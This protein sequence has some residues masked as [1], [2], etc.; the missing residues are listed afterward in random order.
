MDKRSRLDRLVAA[1]KGQDL[2]WVL[3]TLPENIFYYS[4]FRT[5][6][7]TR[8]I[9]VLVPVRESREP[10]LI[11]SYIDNKLVRE[12]IWSPHWFQEAVVWGPSDDFKHKTHW[13]ALAAYLKPG[14]KIGVDAVQL[15]FYD[16]L[17]KLFPGLKVINLQAAILDLRMVKGPDE[18]DKIKKAFKLAEEVMARVPE[19]LSP[20]ATESDVAAEMNYAA[21]KA[22]AD[23]LFYPTLVSCGPK[24]SAYHSPPLRRPI[25]PGQIVRIAFGLQVD[26]YG[27]DIVRTFCV[28]QPPAEV[29]PLKE[30]FFEAQEALFDMIKPGVTSADM[31][32][33]CE[34]VFQRHG[35]L[36]NWSYNIGHGLALTI[37]EPP[38][39]AGV[40]A[41]PI[42]ENM[43]LAIEPGLAC[44]P[45]G[46][47]AHCDGIRVTATG[48]ERLSFGLR[49]VNV[50]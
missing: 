1:A 36:K 2:D 30:A 31:I 37:H 5:M 29:R 27:S 4:G 14:V 11:A 25:V 50:V 46:A 28:G 42:R 44:P 38:R 15:D 18:V 8:F 7:Y 20:K 12:K 39:I 48:C 47:F 26:G 43:I 10:V 6:F 16:G 22:G 24:M 34:T 21:L 17:L 35:C 45:H 23:D 33:K 40:D 19:W 32:K 41:T 49:D 3:C 13:D 9:G